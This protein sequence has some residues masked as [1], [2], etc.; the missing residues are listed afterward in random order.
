MRQRRLAALSLLLTTLMA[1]FVVSPASPAQ[2][3]AVDYVALGDSYSSG[4]GTSGLS[5]LCL[6]SQQSY[7][8]Q[9]AEAHQV[10]SFS[11]AACAGAVTDNVRDFQIW[12]LNSRTDAVTITIGGN[13]VGFASAMITC[14]FG[15]TA[16]C[17]DAVDDGR[18][19]AQTT[20]IGDLDATYAAI[21]RRA[22]NAKVYVLGY[23]RLFEETSCPGGLSLTKRRALNQA[24][25]ELSDLIAGRVGA[26]G[27]TYVDVRG[28]FAGHGICGS[29]PWINNFSVSVNAFHP[30][31]AGYRNGYLP[32]LTAVTG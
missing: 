21:H 19:Y 29:T 25:D 12:A 1:G 24:A 8:P 4:V 6:Q 16:S 32:A 3:A 15:S 26:A 22:P 18:D 27:F 20:L 7:A 10:S 17:L 9:W 13:D 30:N 2:A 5:G 11:F 23:P 14:T 31:A 28:A